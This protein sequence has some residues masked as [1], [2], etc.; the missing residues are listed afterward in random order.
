MQLPCL[1]LSSVVDDTLQIFFV[2][3]LFCD[4][5]FEPADLCMHFKF[6]FVHAFQDQE[7]INVPT[8]FPWGEKLFVPIDILTKIFENL[9]VITL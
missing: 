4:W 9:R 8:M 5:Q 6:G 7:N 1:S 3:R 2:K